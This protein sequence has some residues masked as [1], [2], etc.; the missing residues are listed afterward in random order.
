VQAHQDIYY[1]AIAESTEGA[2]ATPFVLFMLT[3]IR[4]AL[5]ELEENGPQGKAQ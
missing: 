3:M 4:A 2:L 1:L 5:D